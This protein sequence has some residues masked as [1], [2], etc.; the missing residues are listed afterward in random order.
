MHLLEIFNKHTQIATKRRKKTENY[1]D[2]I[3]KKY[4]THYS[5][6]G[7]FQSYKATLLSC[8]VRNYKYL[9]FFKTL[10]KNILNTS[11]QFGGMSTPLR[12]W[13]KEQQLQH[14]SALSTT[15]AVCSY[16]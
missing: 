10:K 5:G 8:E 7:I 4:A 1:E 16:A 14:K 15:A 11:V 12:P 6:L 9:K 3:M 13:Y 2:C